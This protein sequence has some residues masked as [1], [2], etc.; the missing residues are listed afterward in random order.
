MTITTANDNG[1]QGWSALIVHQSPGD[2]IPAA[3]NPRTH[4]EKQI[5]QIM[6]SICQFGFTNPVLVDADNRIVA[7]HGRAE[8]ATRLGLAT[9]PTIRLP[10]LSPAELRALALADNK[11]ALNAG[12]DEDTLRIELGELCAMDLSFDLDITGFSTAEIDVIEGSRKARADAALDEGADREPSPSPV[13]VQ[14]DVWLLGRHRLL[15]G[16]SRDGTCFARLMGQDRARMVLSDPPFNVP[17]DGHVCGAGAVHHREFAM[18]SGEMSRETF[19]R[20]LETVFANE[21]RYSVDGALH[22]QFMDWRHVQEMTAAGE[23]VYSG[24]RN[25]CVWVK[26]NG[27]MGSLYRSQHEL[28]F[29]WKAGNAAHV[30][31]VELGRNGRYR[32]NTWSYRGV[33]RTGRGS[34]LALHPT[35]KPV[36]M[37]MD[38][39][40]DVSK[41][42]DIV[43]DAF[44][45]SGSTLLAAEKTRRRARLIEFEPGYCDVTIERWQKLAGRSARL[46]GT[47]ETFEEVKSRRI[48]GLT[49]V[50]PLDEEAA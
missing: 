40:R 18:A 37:L 13:T 50:D 8:A 23:A 2:L 16:D 36:V 3:R 20:F 29:V 42:G 1:K 24:L 33:I 4:P 17:V 31:N 30:N 48:E 35:V 9:I 46:Q 26:D 43:L 49:F 21:V 15:C 27:G 6:G 39:I 45:G 12:W 7:G 32:T 25:I 22:F 41:R 47:G 10:H 5:T 38:A 34:E 19:T 14:G 28:V 44:G 11:I